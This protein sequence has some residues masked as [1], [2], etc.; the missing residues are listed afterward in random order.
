MLAPRCPGPGRKSPLW[1]GDNAPGLAEKQKFVVSLRTHTPL[2]E[3]GLHSDLLW[4]TRVSLPERYPG[5]P[6]RGWSS[7]TAGAVGEE[8]AREAAHAAPRAQGRESRRHSRLRPALP[9]SPTSAWDLPKLPR[10]LVAQPWLRSGAETVRV[11][12]ARSCAA[13][14]GSRLGRRVPVGTVGTTG[15]GQAPGPDPAGPRPGDSQ[16]SLA[17]VTGLPRTLSSPTSAWLLPGSRAGRKQ[18]PGAHRPCARRGQGRQPGVERTVSRAAP[19]LPLESGVEHSASLSRANEEDSLDNSTTYLRA[20]DGWASLPAPRKPSVGPQLRRAGDWGVGRR[21]GPAGLHPKGCHLP[22]HPGT[23]Q[24]AG[25]CWRGWGGAFS[26]GHLP[27]RGG[28]G[29]RAHASASFC[30]FTYF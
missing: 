30:A 17:R 21:W 10:L 16:A 19:T 11:W 5:Q 9:D 13:P 20:W 15:T 26:G 4:E 23:H 2:P 25:C 27:C 1:V 18:Q 24:A 12:D 7:G 28:R 22:Q 8:A 14:A 29:E 6:L 3:S